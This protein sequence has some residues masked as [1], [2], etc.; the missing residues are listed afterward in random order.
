MKK[1][2][3]VAFGMCPNDS[4]HDKINILNSYNKIRFLIALYL[5]SVSENQPNLLSNWLTDKDKRYYFYHVNYVKMLPCCLFHLFF[6]L[7]SCNT[8]LSFPFFLFLFTEKNPHHYLLVNSRSHF[9]Y[10]FGRVFVMTWWVPSVGC[11]LSRGWRLPPP[12][13]DYAVTV[14]MSCKVC[15]AR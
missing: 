5:V 10:C 6:L 4:F 9:N 2:S 3:I 13:P 14:T 7:F 11:S 1:K 12:S 15:S 8:V